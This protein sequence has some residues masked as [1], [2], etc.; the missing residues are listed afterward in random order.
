MKQLKFYGIFLFLCL[1]ISASKH[2]IGS[3]TPG[4]MGICLHSV[5]GH[6]RHC[7]V[8]N[9]IPVVYWGSE[10]AYYNP[11][12]FNGSQNVWEYYFEPVSHLNYAHGDTIHQ[13]CQSDC[14]LFSYL[15]MSQPM[16]TEAYRLIKKYIKIKPVVQHKIDEFY[17]TYMVG[18]KNI[19]IHIRGTDKVLEEKIVSPERMILEALKYADSETQFLIATDEKQILDKMINLLKD[20]N[21]VYYDCYRSENNHPLHVRGKPS[22]AQL[23]EDVVVE[24]ALLAKCDV[25]VH[26]LSNVSAVAL[27]LNPEMENVT[28]V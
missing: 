8:N 7:E 16:R 27:Y 22:Y 13:F 12:G 21:V 3:W 6:L 18:K 17:R 28:L 19:G 1:S 2:V 25:F 26:T 24:M 5:L 4:G 23:G 20:Y 9:K 14:G 10:S 11:G 15:Y